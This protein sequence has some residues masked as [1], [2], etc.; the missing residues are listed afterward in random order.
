MLCQWRF[1]SAG[2][3]ATIAA[4]VNTVDFSRALTVLIVLDVATA[5][6]VCAGTGFSLSV[7]RE[8]NIRICAGCVCAGTGFHINHGTA[9]F[10][11]GFDCCVVHPTPSHTPEDPISFVVGFGGELYFSASEVPGTNVQFGFIFRLFL[12][13]T[14]LCGM[15]Y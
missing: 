4:G 1:F 15:G 8:R 7:A 10:L 12:Y 3:E 5:G 13:G 11:A 9:G 14:C 2:H 6:R